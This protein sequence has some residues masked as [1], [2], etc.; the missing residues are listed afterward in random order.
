MGIKT[1]LPYHFDF[2]YDIKTVGELIEKIN[3]S[4]E[5]LDSIAQHREF[6]ESNGVT[7]PYDTLEKLLTERKSLRKKNKKRRVNV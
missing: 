3:D 2:W 4:M 7:F 1:E 6:L 5:V